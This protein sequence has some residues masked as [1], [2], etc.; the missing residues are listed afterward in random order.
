MLGCAG[1]NYPADRS[2]CLLYDKLKTWVNRS[3]KPP[4]PGRLAR[5]PRRLAVAE[6]LLGGLRAAGPRR[7]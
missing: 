4:S 2:Q 6:G 1:V 3:Q 5:V 7:G